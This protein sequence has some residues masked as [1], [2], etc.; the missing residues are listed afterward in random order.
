MKH[1]TQVKLITIITM[2]FLTAYPVAELTRA[3]VQY[4]IQPLLRAQS[5]GTTIIWITPFKNVPDLNLFYCELAVIW[6]LYLA[7]PMILNAVFN[8]VFKMGMRYR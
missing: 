1:L 3:I 6:S 4:N 8:L 5:E 2:M 7:I